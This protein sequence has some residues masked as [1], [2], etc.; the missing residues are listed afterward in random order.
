MVLRKLW[1]ISWILYGE[2]KTEME[3]VKESVMAEMN[4]IKTELRK[5]NN[6]YL[7]P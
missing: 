7:T 6:D 5:G 2:V 4:C 3:N 1:E